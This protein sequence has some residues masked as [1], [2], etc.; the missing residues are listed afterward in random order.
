MLSGVVVKRGAVA[1][2]CGPRTWENSFSIRQGQPVE[3]FWGI[4]MRV[5]HEIYCISAT[6]EARLF[7]CIYWSILNKYDLNPRFCCQCPIIFSPIIYSFMLSG[8][9]KL[10]CVS[11]SVTFMIPHRWACCWLSTAEVFIYSLLGE[12]KKKKISLTPTQ[13]RNG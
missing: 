6:A 13:K 11:D 2:Q 5:L 12:I 7:L 9:Y 10:Q 8:P 4:V 3:S 1:E